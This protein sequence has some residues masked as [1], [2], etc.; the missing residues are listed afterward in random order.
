[1][2]SLFRP[3]LLLA[4]ALPLLL[5]GCGDKEP[6]QRTAFT[7]FLQTRIIDKPGVHAPKLTDDERKPLVTTAHTMLLFPISARAWTLQCSL[8]L[9]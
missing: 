8:S 5:T 2:K 9:A 6:E 7:Q 4:V 1:M 3:V